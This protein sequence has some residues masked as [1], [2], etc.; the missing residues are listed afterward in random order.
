MLSQLIEQPFYV[1]S[2][3]ISLPMYLACISLSQLIEQ[4]FYGELRTKQQLGY[5]VSSSVSEQV[6]HLP[7]PPALPS[8]AKVTSPYLAISPH[9]SLH[10][11]PCLCGPT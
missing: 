11:P 10:P 9:T 5:I 4:P 2:A 7:P 3:C 6:R 1:L 8:M